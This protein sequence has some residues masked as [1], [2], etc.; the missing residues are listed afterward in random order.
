MLRAVGGYCTTAHNREPR[1]H[2][3]QMAGCEVHP[4]QQECVT[5]AFSE[6]KVVEW[7]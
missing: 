1:R 3:F 6:R 7:N 4:G 5:A 2:V